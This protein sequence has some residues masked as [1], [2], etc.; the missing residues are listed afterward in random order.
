MP[1]VPDFPCQHKDCTAENR[2]CDEHKYILFI[3]DARDNSVFEIPSGR[4]MQTFR[5]YKE[6]IFEAKGIDIEMQRLVFSGAERADDTKHGGIQY[7]S[8]L[9]LVLRQ[10]VPTKS[11]RNI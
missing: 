1:V 8:T 2:I 6:R 3:K 7:Q 9:H 5:W 11:A 4:G 10:N